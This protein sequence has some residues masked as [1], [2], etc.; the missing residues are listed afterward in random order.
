MFRNKTLVC[1]VSIDFQKLKIAFD[2]VTFIINTR[3][4]D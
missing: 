2:V 4:T 1:L 3:I